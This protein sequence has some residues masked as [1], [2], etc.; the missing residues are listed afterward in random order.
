VHGWGH[1]VPV[2]SVAVLKIR[3]NTDQHK[4][5]GRGRTEVRWVDL[6]QLDML[7]QVMIW[8]R[9]P[10]WGRG[11]VVWAHAVYAPFCCLCCQL[12]LPDLLLLH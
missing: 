7:E 6:F 12:L 3:L 9:C 4:E 2:V 8:V 1:N 5:R 11:L 10:G